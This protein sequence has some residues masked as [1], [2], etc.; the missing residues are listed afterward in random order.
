MKI[1]IRGS[2]FETN[3]SSSH[4]FIHI[5]KETFEAWKRGEKILTW[6]GESLRHCDEGKFIESVKDEL[7]SR[8]SGSVYKDKNFADASGREEDPCWWSGTYE[9]V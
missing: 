6:G 8:E 3:S 4:T 1:T 9:G 7:H 2:V 5:K